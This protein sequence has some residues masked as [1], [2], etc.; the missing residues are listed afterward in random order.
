M[1]RFLEK[2]QQTG[3]EDYE[4][5]AIPSGED[6]KSVLRAYE[7]QTSRFDW[8][9]IIRAVAATLDIRSSPSDEPLPSVLFE[10][11]LTTLP[12]VQHFPEDKFIT[13]KTRKGVL[14][15][16]VWAHQIL[17]L[18]VLVKNHDNISDSNAR[19][20]KFGTAIQEHIVIEFS[21][22]YSD[23]LNLTRSPETFLLQSCST[24]E[25]VLQLRA[26]EDVQAIDATCREPLKGY[27]N[28][29]LRNLF[30]NDNASTQRLIEEL[31]C[32]TVAHAIT[33]SQHLYPTREQTSTATTNE[34][35][36]HDPYASR[37]YTAGVSTP[38]VQCVTEFLF[39]N[40][41]TDKTTIEK[42]VSMY[43]NKPF[44]HENAPRTIDILIKKLERP[45]WDGHRVLS[46]P[47]IAR[48]LDELAV[49]I[50]TLLHVVHL[51]DIAKMPVC[52]LTRL[53]VYCKLCQEVWRWDGQSVLKINEHI[54]L[55]V[56]S[57]LIFG[58]DAFP[59]G[60][61]KICLVSKCGWSIFVN[62]FGDSDPSNVGEC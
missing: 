60:F 33:I 59:A 42:Y 41:V 49:V 17:G 47:E 23:T 52:G 20:V 8:H 1:S 30:P 39:E 31:R 4:N 28:R 6:I 9:S 55:E 36:S 38:L 35:S 10:G 62:T 24:H 58:Q 56:L 22:T 32:V 48:V 34:L 3:G 57:L 37:Q 14:A 2:R 21:R 61:A 7:D 26:D 40:V 15:I 46:W 44:H 43:E 13:I 16:V 18:T 45:Y 29:V 51:R 54:W 5:R 25:T 12:L 19:D 53:S 11:L 27:G 50:L